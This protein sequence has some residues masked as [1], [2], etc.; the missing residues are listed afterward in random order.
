MLSKKLLGWLGS[1]R[2][3]E[4]SYIQLATGH[5]VPQGTVLGPALFSNLINLDE[6]IE[7]ILSKF[8][9]NTKLGGSINLPESRMVLQR[10]LERLNKRTDATRM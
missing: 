9:D 4:R 10:N 2:G 7:S 6:R 8:V 5:R 1:G 3:G